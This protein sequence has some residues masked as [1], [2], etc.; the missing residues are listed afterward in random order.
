[1]LKLS[2]GKP[3][4]FA[5]AA[6]VAALC[7]FVVPAFST[8]L[9]NGDGSINTAGTQVTI[10]PAG[11]VPTVM[12]LSMTLINDDTTNSILFCPNAAATSHRPGMRVRYGARSSPER[13][14]WSSG[15]AGCIQRSSAGRRPVVKHNTDLLAR[16]R[17][18]AEKDVPVE[19]IL[20]E[21]LRRIETQLDEIET[22]KKKN[23]GGLADWPKIR[24]GFVVAL[25][26]AVV[27]GL[28]ATFLQAR[29]NATNRKADVQRIEKLEAWRE[30]HTEN[31]R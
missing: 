18:E 7:L 8:Q 28:F 6:F 9:Y 16:L 19:V 25:L 20:L 4:R 27:G 11:T 23:G 17:A 12:V 13:S 14:R 15:Y 31:G 29:D 30:R 24:T 2:Y 10:A 26:V 1:M 22:A 5:A 21:T 3:V